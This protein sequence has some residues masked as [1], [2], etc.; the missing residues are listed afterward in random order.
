MKHFK[1]LWLKNPDN[2]V[3]N[4]PPYTSYATDNGWGMFDNLVTQFFQPRGSKVFRNLSTY[5]NW[6]KIHVW[7]I[8]LVSELEELQQFSLNTFFNESPVSVSKI[9]P[10][11]TN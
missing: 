5:D 1:S 11:A 4:L 10:E 3:F 6:S 2:Q 8:F 9:Q 7:I